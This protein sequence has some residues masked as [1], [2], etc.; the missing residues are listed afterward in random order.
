[1]AFSDLS[2]VGQESADASGQAVAGV[3]DIDGDGYDDIAIGAPKNDMGFTDSGATYIYNVAQNSPPRKIKSLSISPPPGEQK[4]Q[5]DMVF[6][7]TASDIQCYN[8]RRAS[9]YL[10]KKGFSVR[11]IF[12]PQPFSKRY[13]F[14]LS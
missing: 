11:I 7:S 3:G 9:S 4:E 2:F 12:L 13:S 8:I 1:M 6:I 5:P 10:K 14:L